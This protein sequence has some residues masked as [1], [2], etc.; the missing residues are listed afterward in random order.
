MQ[1]HSE[2]WDIKQS[3]V[4]VDNQICF[5]G[6]LLIQTKKLMQMKPVFMSTF[7]YVQSDRVW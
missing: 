3:T 5:T 2:T 6:A 7:S 1:D 4:I